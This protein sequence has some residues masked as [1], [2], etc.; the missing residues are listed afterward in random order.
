MGFPTINDIAAHQS[1]AVGALIDEAARAVPELSGLNDRGERIEAA[2]YMETISG[3]SY[4][5][6][7]RTALPRGGF[8]AANTGTDALV[9]TVTPKTVDTY[10]L[11]PRWECDKAVANAFER[12]AEAYIAQEGIALTRGALMDLAQAFYYGTDAT[13]GLADAF[14][15]LLDLVDASMVVDA[16]GTTVATASSVWAVRFGP[17][18]VAWVLGKEGAIELSDVSVQVV[19]DGTGKRFP[20]Y[21]QDLLARP[22]LQVGAKWSVGRIKNITEDAGKTLDDDMLSDLVAKFPVGWR[23]NVIF[24]SRRSRK[25]LQQ[26]R[27]AT[28]ATGAPAPTPMD[29]DGIPI[30]AS[31][32]IVDTEPLA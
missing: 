16:G 17:E 25:Q 29:H 11:N 9:S 3:L 26:S 7:I 14:P 23:P 2:G 21:V 18:G 4:K 22:G 30:L 6:P 15:G 31:D 5:V 28:N 24:M 10:I 32:S 27:T 13:L 8:R 12:G 20:A 19:D 1:E